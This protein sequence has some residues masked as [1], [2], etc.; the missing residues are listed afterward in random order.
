MATIHIT[1]DDAADQVLSDDPFDLLVGMMLDQGMAPATP[2]SPWSTSM[3][4][5]A[6]S[7]P[8]PDSSRR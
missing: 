5:S 6:R 1:G 3:P 7:A 8:L 4:S 2:A